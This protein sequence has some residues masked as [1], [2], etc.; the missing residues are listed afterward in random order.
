MTII[1]PSEVLQRAN[2]SEVD[3]WQELALLFYQQ[4]RLTL[5]QAANLTGLDLLSFQRLLGRR[6]IY[7]HYDEEELA[8]DLA[9]V[10][11]MS[12]C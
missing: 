6:N 8:A 5:G 12:L 3:F 11:K 1:V 9:A 7:I 2:L 4:K 10:E